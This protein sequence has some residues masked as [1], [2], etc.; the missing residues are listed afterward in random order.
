[1]KNRYNPVVARDIRA[2]FWRSSC[3]GGLACAE[4]DDS[5]DGGGPSRDA[6]SCL[7]MRQ[8]LGCT[9][10]KVVDLDPRQADVLILARSIGIH[11]HRFRIGHA[12]RGS[13]RRCSR[14]WFKPTR[15]MCASAIRRCR[16]GKA[17]RRFHRRLLCFATAGGL[18]AATRRRSSRR[19]VSAPMDGN[20][21]T[22]AS[23]QAALAYYKP[24]PMASTIASFCWPPMARPTA[25]SRVR[26][27]TGTLR[28]HGAAC[29]DALAQVNAMVAL[30]VR[31]IVLGVGPV[32]RTT[33]AKE[34]PCLDAMAHA[35]GAAASP[36]SPG[37]YAASDPVQLQWP[38]S[39]SSVASRARRA[40]VRFRTPVEDTSTIAVFL[41]GNQIPRASGDGW[42]LDSSTNPPSVLITGTYCDQIQQFQ[43]STV[44]ARFGCPPCVDIQGCK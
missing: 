2:S 35:G 13:G 33:P 1:M 15:R 20:T 25:P 39:R 5:V 7:T 10:T 14:I 16:A 43:V 6:P 24:L 12:L 21:P 31:V 17:A 34:R 4:V 11:G 30:G 26:C 37:F 22:A 38:S 3:W 27:R 36:G 44:E 8:P 18:A 28:C 41:D 32:L 23:L 9:V 19:R 29:T 42:H 40:S